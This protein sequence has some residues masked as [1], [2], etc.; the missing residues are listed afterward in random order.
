MKIK[1]LIS[2]L[3]LSAVMMTGVVLAAQDIGIDGVI[4]IEEALESSQDSNNTSNEEAANEMINSEVDASFELSQIKVQQ[5]LL[6]EVVE[7]IEENIDNIVD[8]VYNYDEQHSGGGVVEPSGTVTDQDVTIDYENAF[9]I[10]GVNTGD[11]AGAFANTESFAQLISQ[12]YSLNLPVLSSNGSIASVVEMRN[13]R[14]ADEL[15]FPDET[16]QEMK[17]EMISYAIENEGQW[18]VALIG[19]YI[20]LGMVEVFSDEA[21]LNSVL[22]SAGISSIQ[23]IKIVSLYDYGMEIIYFS[24]DE[25]KE[26][27]IPYKYNPYLYENMN[28]G[29]VHTIQELMNIISQVY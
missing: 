17:A 1:K 19:E 29:Q 6:S 3:T 27:A 12:D 26:Y 18:K 14:G 4:G 20:P 21:K 8:S 9:K 5:S 7:E 28:E 10:Y 24:S 25:Q 11:V 16:D 23:D 13:I 2:I 22:S 15:V